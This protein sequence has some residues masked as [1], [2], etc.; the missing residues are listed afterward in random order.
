MLVN[1][2]LVC[3]EK[4]VE[5]FFIFFLEIAKTVLKNSCLQLGQGVVLKQLY[6]YTRLLATIRL[7][8]VGNF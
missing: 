6:G 1:F 3:L 5:R 8:D 4:K 2:G 7:S